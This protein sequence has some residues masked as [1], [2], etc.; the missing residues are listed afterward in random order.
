MSTKGLTGTNYEIRI[1]ELKKEFFERIK[2]VISTQ[3]KGIK[4]GGYYTEPVNQY[5]EKVFNPYTRPVDGEEV[6]VP[7][8]KEEWGT[9][10]ANL[11][12]MTPVP[13]PKMVFYC[14]ALDILTPPL[15]SEKLLRFGYAV[16]GGKLIPCAFFVQVVCLEDVFDGVT[17]P[18]PHYFAVDPIAIESN[19]VVDYYVGVSVDK[20]LVQ[21][22]IFSKN[23]QDFPLEALIR[24]IE[25]NK[26]EL[27]EKRKQEKIEREAQRQ[28]DLEE[29]AERERQAR[30]NKGLLYLIRHAR[31]AKDSY[32]NPN[33]GIS[34]EGRSDAMILGNKLKKEL[35]DEE[36]VIWTSSARRAVETTEVLQKMLNV[37]DVR[38]E[39][40]LW[41]DSEHH[42]HFL[43][44]ERE[45]DS[46]QGK[47]LLVIT[48]YG[49]VEDFPSYL[50]SELSGN[51]ASYCCGVVIEGFSEP[52]LLTRASCKGVYC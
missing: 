7:L 44:L 39:E 21:Q 50:S 52:S 47:V 42:S 43:W 3:R 8:P 41:S 16:Q 37:K 26:K 6:C 13:W 45:L 10:Y 49:Y 20:E 15:L 2:Q 36:V 51:D 23:P 40:K 5:L 22:W 33:P 27:E 17:I 25:T 9:Q 18:T 14:Y 19:V 28:R 46:F 34:E 38:V 4:E 31:Y 32:Q 11:S 29:A 1:E 48:H 12:Y 35:K 24:K 30:I